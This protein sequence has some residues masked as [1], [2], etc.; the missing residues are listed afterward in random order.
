MKKILLYT[1]ISGICCHL[2]YNTVQAQVKTKIYFE[3]ISTTTIK[4]ALDNEAVIKIIPPEVFD[5]LLSKEIIE[6]TDT[7]EYKDKFAVAVDVDIDLIAKANKVTEKEFV[8]YYLSLTAEK[9]LNLSLRFNIFS[10]SENSILSIFTTHEITDSITAKEN[11]LNAIW[12]TRI[13]QGDKIYLMLKVPK[14]E[15]GKNRLNISRAG[16]GH[17]KVGGEFFGNS[18]ASATCNINVACTEGNGWEDERGAVALIISDDN[19]LCTGTLLMNTCGTNIPYLLTANHCLDANVANW[20]FQFQ[21]WSNTCT[22]NGTYREDLQF[23]G[24]TLRANDA[25]TDFALLEMNTVPAANS[26]ITYA[27]WDRTTTAATSGAG[28]HHPQGDLMKV[29]LFDQTATSVSWVSGASNYWR[30]SFTLNQGIVQHGSSGSALF[31]QDHRVAGQL[32]GNQNNICGNPGTNTCWCTIQIPSIGEYGRFDLSWTGGGTNATRLSNWLDPSGSGATT[33]NTTNVSSLEKDPNTLSISGSSV[34]CSGTSTAYTIPNLPAGATVSWSATPS[35]IV[36]INSPTATQTTLSMIGNAPVQ[37]KAAITLCGNTVD[38]YFAVA[39]GVPEPVESLTIDGVDP[40]TSA[41]CYASTIVAYPGVIE[42]NTTYEWSLPGDW[43]AI[44]TGT[45]S[46]STVDYMLG[47]NPGTDGGLFVRRLNQCGYS[48]FY[49]V[50]VT[51]D[52]WCRSFLVIPNPAK[53]NITIDGQTKDIREVQIIDK[54]GQVK[55]M[56]KFGS[57]MQRVNLNISG[58]APD[59]YY[60]KVFDGKE[61]KSK[62]VV[63][64]K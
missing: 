39:V 29:S 53:D 32:R 18:G 31:N 40:E 45:S 6:D 33:T 1:T 36:T 52:P 16:L 58:L 61:W 30:V 7:R 13:Y 17:K 5:K 11:N 46:A 55:R 59:I 51:F 63:V 22:P 2:H 64:V 26:G 48:S 60:I 42:A 50:L 44:E 47:V 38:K 20:V 12:A 24:C 14:N 54:T 19:E 34:L 25:A 56:F 35:G 4:A 23:N 21:T 10:L 9:A 43:T 57:N 62:P 3:G 15:E 49:S 27:G 37:L 8:F 28:L 41:I